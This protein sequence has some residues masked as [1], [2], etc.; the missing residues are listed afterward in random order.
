MPDARHPGKD[1]MAA[2]LNQALAEGDTYESS[3]QVGL[4]MAK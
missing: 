2:A 1:E 3:E 4:I